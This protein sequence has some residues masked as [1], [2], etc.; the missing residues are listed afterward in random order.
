MLATA[1][2]MLALA[3]MLP[4]AAA[5]LAEVFLEANIWILL[6]LSFQKMPPLQKMSR[7]TGTRVVQTMSWTEAHCWWLITSNVT[8]S[9]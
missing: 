1:R 8:S 3:L 9:N 4:E 7:A 2:L 5:V 6:D